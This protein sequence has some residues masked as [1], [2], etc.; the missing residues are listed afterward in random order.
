MEYL[1]IVFAFIL[2]FFIYLVIPIESKS[3]IEYNLPSEPLQVYNY[4][5]SSYFPRNII[6]P[7]LSKEILKENEKVQI[8]VIESV[9][10]FKFA[11]EIKSSSRFSQVSYFYTLEQNTEGGTHLKVQHTWT[12]QPG[13]YGTLMNRFFYKQENDRNLATEREVLLSQWM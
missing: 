1:K 12:P 4:L 9:I 5:T 10:P 8:E 3:S 11:L 13:L 2:C 6:G 7:G